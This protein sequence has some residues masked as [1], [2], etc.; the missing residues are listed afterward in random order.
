VDDSGSKS[1]TP[2]HDAIDRHFETARVTAFTDGVFA[3][4]ITVLVL[5]IQVPNL[6]SGQSL[7]ASIDEVSP[8]FV[9]W[10]IS[11]FLTGMYW[12]THRG[13][14]SNVRYADLSLV[15]LNLLFLLPVC[16]IPFGSSALGL[17]PDDLLAL[18][19]YGSVLI[20]ATLVRLAM[21][22]YLHHHPTLQW[23]VASRQAYRLTMVALASPLPVYAVAILVADWSALASRILYLAVPALYL[24]LVALLKTDRHT[25]VAAEDLS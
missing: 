23:T 10:V 7:R 25:R 8:T 19:L 4:V 20:A 1:G 5:E 15:W 12:V 6:A 13:L 22:L 9:A 21:A 24:A 2:D 18:R 17:Y 16:L 14:F 11:F 3:I